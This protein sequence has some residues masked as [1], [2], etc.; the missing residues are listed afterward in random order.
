MFSTSQSVLQACRRRR[1]G[2]AHPLLEQL[3]MDTTSRYCT[4]VL[5]YRDEYFCAALR[6]ADSR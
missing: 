6:Y 3:A 5:L 2:I 4:T 1:W